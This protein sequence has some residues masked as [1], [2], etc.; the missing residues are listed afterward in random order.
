MMSIEF[1]SRLQYPTGFRLD[2][3]FATDAAV[4]ALF[5]PSGSGKSTVLS[6]IAG[7]RTPDQGRIR[8]AERVLLDSAAGVDIDPPAR[9][10]GYVFQQ[11]LLFP[12][13]TVRDNLL[14][15]WHRR[16][17][18][19]RGLDPEHV[20]GALDLRELLSRF[21]GTLSGGQRQRVALGRALLCAPDLLLLDEPLASIDAD[22]K[23]DLLQYIERV[24]AECG[25]PVLYVT[26]DA[27]EVRRFCQWVVR[28]HD[29]RVTGAG[30]P[31]TAL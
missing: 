21:P 7:L 19:A 11:H 24:V 16:P 20:F 30:P 5:G 31:A 6:L 13:R 28:L 3:A 17:A 10:I 29:G 25:A 22:A 14:Y 8:L 12:H 4:T 15:G 2:A 26:H 9:R 18:T 1:D 27:D 23:E